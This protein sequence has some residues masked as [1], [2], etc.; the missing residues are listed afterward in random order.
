[1]A[2]GPWRYGAL[3]GYTSVGAGTSVVNAR[4]NCLPE[5][6]IHELQRMPT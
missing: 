1:M 3:I 5:V 4:L 2:S 6:T